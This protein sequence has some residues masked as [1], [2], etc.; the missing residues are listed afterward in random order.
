MT[1]ENDAN[2]GA[3]GSE[4][5]DSES[6]A[7]SSVVLA[8][9]GDMSLAVE[10]RVGSAK[11]SLR[12]LLDCTPGTVLALDAPVG[13][14]V[15]LLVGGQLVARGELVAIDS[16]VGLRIVEIVTEGGSDEA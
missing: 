10:V 16:Q 11:I 7:L 13:G 14:L 3:S 12:E 4:G 8:A 6:S 9:L 5:A 1:D 15:D 2:E